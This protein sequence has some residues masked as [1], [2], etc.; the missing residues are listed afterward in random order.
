MHVFVIALTSRKRQGRSLL[1]E[2]RDYMVFA[3]NIADDDLGT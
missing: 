1:T 2:N 3:S